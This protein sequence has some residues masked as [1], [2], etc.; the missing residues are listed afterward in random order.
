MHLER[1]MILPPI[2]HN[3]P[4]KP[5]NFHGALAQEKSGKNRPERQ[6]QPAFRRLDISVG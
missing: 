4:K 3:P 6:Y 5:I 1:W 2:H